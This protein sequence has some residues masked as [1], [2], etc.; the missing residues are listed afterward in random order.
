MRCRGRSSASRSRHRCKRSGVA[1]PPLPRRNSRRTQPRSRLP[2]TAEA[3][4]TQASRETTRVRCQQ[5]RWCLVWRAGRP[6]AAGSGSAATV[7]P[8]RAA[9]AAA[10]WQ[11][12]RRP[13]RRQLQ[14]A[15]QVRTRRLHVARS[16]REGPWSGSSPSC[17]PWH[18]RRCPR[19]RSRACATGAWI[20]RAASGGAHMMCGRS[21]TCLRGVAC[22]PAA[23]IA[24]V[25]P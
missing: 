11:G 2:L 15:L 20:Q 6:S 14:S 5:R 3:L 23:C 13:R 8:V 1:R 22:Q 4:W 24:P 7:W 25:D 10:A 18:L 17:A 21:A 12:H 9:S 16:L 19:A